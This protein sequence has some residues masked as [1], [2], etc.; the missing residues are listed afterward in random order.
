MLTAAPSSASSKSADWQWQA[1]VGTCA[2]RQQIDDAGSMFEV[3]RTPGNDQTGITLQDRRDRPSSWKTFEGA[4]VTI[5]PGPSMVADVSVGP[6]DL[7]R[8]RSVSVSIEDPTF[9][10]SFS[11]ASTLVVSHEKF[12]VLRTPIRSPAVAAKALRK[13]EDKTMREWG[14]DA[15]A[16][17]ALKSRPIPSASLSGSLTPNDYPLLPAQYQVQGDVIARLDVGSDGTVHECVGLNK[18]VNADFNFATCR[19]LMRRARFHPALDAGGQPVAAPFVVIVR[20][21]FRR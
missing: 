6:G 15:V 3:R 14:I 17:R 18:K 1:V 16:W 20:F 21:R 7:P 13:C 2:L 4:S 12:G 19:A 8:S 11:E 10:N 5:E 9:M